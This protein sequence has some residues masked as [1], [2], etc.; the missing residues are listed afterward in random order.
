[1]IGHKV[2]TVGLL[3]VFALSMTHLRLFPRGS[4]EDFMLAM[5]LEARVTALA[6]GL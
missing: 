2:C 1:M 6:A 3:I 5:K 4:Y